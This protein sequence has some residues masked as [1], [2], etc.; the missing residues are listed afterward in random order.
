MKV[1]YL[2][3]VHAPFDLA[4]KKEEI[5]DVT[6]RQARNLLKQGCA[7]IVEDKTKERTVYGDADERHDI[8]RGGLAAGTS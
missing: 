5:K 6:A 3:T 8:E 4:G 7:E 2:K 1:R